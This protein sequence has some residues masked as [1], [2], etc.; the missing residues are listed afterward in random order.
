MDD[1]ANVVHRTLDGPDPPG[2]SGASIFIGA[3][4]EGSRS[5][6]SSEASKGRGPT[7]IWSWRPAAASGDWDPAAA[8]ALGSSTVPGSRDPEPSA[9]EPPS[10]CV[11]CGSGRS[12]NSTMLTASEVAV[13]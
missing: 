3:G 2:G 8:T 11:L 6:V 4:L 12:V 10:S 1:L 9:G 13:M 5:F 7:T